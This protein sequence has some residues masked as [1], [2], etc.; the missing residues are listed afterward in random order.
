MF[1]NQEQQKFTIAV[2]GAGGACVAF[3]HHLVVSLAPSQAAALRVQVFEP[4]PC[5]G[6][7]LAYQ[8]DEETLLLNRV[9]ETMSVSAS[10][11][12]TFSAWLRWKSHH[13]RELR[14]VSAANLS[15]AYVPRPVFGRFLADFFRETL[16][17]ARQ[18][19]LEI[20]V[21]PAAV[22]GI[23]RGT[24]YL[25]ETPGARYE[26]DSVVLAVG[27]TGARDHYQL[28]GHARFLDSPYP[29]RQRI[30]PLLGARRICVIG[31][32]LSAVDVAVSLREMGYQ[33]GIDLVSRG[34]SLPFVRGRQAQ[35]HQPRYLTQAA[36]IRLSNH[37]ATRI[38]L[39]ALGRLLRAELRTVGYDW[40]AL[41][42]DSAD[43]LASLRADTG[44]AGE[45]CQWQL[46]LAATNAVVSTAWHALDAASQ[47][48]VLKR[49]ARQWRARRAPM[50][51]ENALKLLQMIERGQL[52]LLRGAPAFDRSSADAISA[53][54]AAGTVRY[55]Y[56]IN[57]T[58]SAQWVD[59]PQDSALV[60]QMLQDGL[61]V[62]DPR[63]GIR[64]DFGTGAVIDQHNEP[65]WNLRALGQIT[66]GSYFFVSSLEMIAR[67][68]RRIADD[69]LATLPYEGRR[70]IGQ[71]TLVP[72]AE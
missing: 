3:L 8:E 21:V 13:A 10:D 52:R 24:R 66:N 43:P 48:V 35:A 47:D 65:D 45:V 5:A 42:R 41:F 25:I 61:A 16:D 71:P 26:A 28:G 4:R 11:Y 51:R 44:A 49:F 69:L 19:G 50:P 62:R 40:R 23:R 20:D 67:H 22:Q 37:G 31:A 68:A 18:K 57:A 64:V 9:A 59:T 72:V 36:L 70:V 30:R 39:R 60:W 6:P 7:G 15:A 2:I 53:T 17:S 14:P 29:V 12:S 54:T 58:G 33:G 34:G 27:N 46:V 32:G 55:D 38:G 56:V 63:G 1:D